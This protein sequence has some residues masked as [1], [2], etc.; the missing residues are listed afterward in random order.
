MQAIKGFEEFIVELAGLVEKGERNKEKQIEVLG[1]KLD[2]VRGQEL[3]QRELNISQQQRDF[4]YNLRCLKIA[5]DE[6][7]R[8]ANL[9][10]AKY[11]VDAELILIDVALLELNLEASRLHCKLYQLL[12]D[13][14]ASCS[15]R[16]IRDS[17]D[18]FLEAKR[19]FSQWF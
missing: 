6:E 9:E 16:Q 5:V 19:Y 17:D 11:E 8:C 3:I 10:V 15:I 1:Y 2:I 18:P 4:N 7:I 12:S 14:G 13:A